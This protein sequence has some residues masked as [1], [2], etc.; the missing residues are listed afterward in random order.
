M[1]ERLLQLDK[2]RITKVENPQQPNGRR[3]IRWVVSLSLALTA[4]S[5]PPFYIWW[6]ASEAIPVRLYIVRSPGGATPQPP[7]TLFTGAGYIEAHRRAIVSTVVA[8]RAVEV[9]VE[10]G[11]YLD[12]GQIIARLDD[13]EIK[14]ELQV[15]HSKVL[16]AEAEL[17]AAQTAANDASPIFDRKQALL[18]N[19]LISAE[20]FDDA[21]AT[22]N[23]AQGNMKVRQRN[24]D[25][26]TS[27]Q[28]QVKRNLTETVIRAPFSGVVTATS[29]QPGE[30]LF[31]QSSGSS[32]RTSVATIVDMTSLEAVVDINETFLDKLILGGPATITLNAYPTWKIDGDV[33]AIS[34]TADRAKA[35]VEVRVRPKVQDKRILPEMGA[36]VIFMNPSSTETPSETSASTIAVPREAVQTLDDKHFIYLA[37]GETLSR[38]GVEVVGD[39]TG[40]FLPVTGVIAGEE[41]AI[42]IDARL[43]DGRPFRAVE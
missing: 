24:L 6:K 22:Y 8:G 31:P 25:E 43:Q 9:P 40:D 17:E 7:A 34:P 14:A 42:P 28:E 18:A 5:L 21:K 27:A 1:N 41:I 12:S 4:F 36:T 3:F 19:K 11:Q 32:A 15:A 13:A 35:T 16:A 38:R 39:P 2:L 30:L 20:A 10:E 23:A 33:I 26:A 29:I 37:E